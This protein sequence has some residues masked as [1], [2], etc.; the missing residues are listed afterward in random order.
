MSNLNTDLP[1]KLQVL[2][3]F[4]FFR[5]SFSLSQP[6]LAVLSQIGTTSPLLTLDLP[7]APPSSKRLTQA[8]TCEATAITRTTVLANQT[9]STKETVSKETQT[10]T[11]T[12]ATA[13]TR[14]ASTVVT[15]TATVSLGLRGRKLLLRGMLLS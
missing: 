14:M 9:T 6:G 12:T 7:V 15:S 10:M 4:L 3:Y 1:I 11:S 2:I 8:P 13:S 5:S